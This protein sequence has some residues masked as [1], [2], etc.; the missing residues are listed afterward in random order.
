MG[1]ATALAAL[2]QGASVCLIEQF[3]RAH[4]FGSSHGD[5]RIFR[6]QYTDGLYIKLMDAAMHGW[7]DLQ[8]SWLSRQNRHPQSDW[9]FRVTGGLDICEKP[10]SGDRTRVDDLCGTY[11]WLGRRYE[12]FENGADISRHFPL[13]RGASRWH[14]QNNTELHAVLQ[15]DG[16]VLRA[17]ACVRAFWEEIETHKSATVMEKAHVSQIHSL[18]EP[19]SVTIDLKDGSRVSAGACVV[20]AG[21]W[22]RSLAR[23]LAL[24]LPLRVKKE[25]VAYFSPTLPIPKKSSGGAPPSTPDMPTTIVHVDNGLNNWGYYCLP[26]IDVPGIKIAAHY[27]GPVWRG[28][29]AH[30]DNDEDD[31]DVTSCGVFEFCSGPAGSGKPQ[32]QHRQTERVLASSARLAEKLFGLEPA[33]AHFVMS[34]D[35]YY[36]ITPDHDFIVGPHPR[37]PHVVFASPCSGHGFKF[38]PGIGDICASLA[39]QGA[40]SAPFTREDLRRFSCDRF[41]PLLTSAQ[42]FARTRPTPK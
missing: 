2:K 17:S 25:T 34:G 13:L 32:P 10:S 31:E 18:S 1:S 6:W 5:G 8:R 11:E 33:E 27:A 39:L 12:R 42:L 40:P 20:A 36:T 14:A 9:L 19:Q 7:E 22:T 35:C 24:R 15:P 41:S 3:S 38:A 4:P 21:A 28:D 29:G 23:G 30:S 16:G 37:H 26:Q